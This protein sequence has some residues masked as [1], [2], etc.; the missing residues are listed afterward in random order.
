MVSLSWRVLY[1][2][3]SVLSIEMHPYL[4]SLSALLP[5]PCNKLIEDHRVARKGDLLSERLICDVPDLFAVDDLPHQVGKAVQTQ[6]FGD[7]AIEAAQPEFFDFFAH[8]T[9]RQ[10]DDFCT[11]KGHVRT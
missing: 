10:R 2:S 11:A 1:T 5:S 4:K 8:D 6:R 7:S 3:T 9:R